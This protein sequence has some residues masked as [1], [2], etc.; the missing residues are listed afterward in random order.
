MNEIEYKNI[1][2]YGTKI[3]ANANKYILV[4]K[5]A[6]DKFENKLQEKIKKLFIEISSD[7]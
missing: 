2:I 3:E 6:T 1:F 7:F 5:K 4:W